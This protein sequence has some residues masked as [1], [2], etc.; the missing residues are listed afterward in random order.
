MAK[1]VTIPSAQAAT[2]MGVPGDYGVSEY[3]G[4]PCDAFWTSAV[5]WEEGEGEDSLHGKPSDAQVSVVY[6]DFPT[7]QEAL[8]EFD[9]IRK[10]RSS[11]MV[12]GIPVEVLPVSSSGDADAFLYQ[13]TAKFFSGSYTGSQ[14]PSEL[15]GRCGRRLLDVSASL[16]T[17][18]SAVADGHSPTEENIVQRS[19]LP[20][21]VDTQLRAAYSQI[22]AG[23]CGQDN[24]PSIVIG[25]WHRVAG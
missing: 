25:P 15:I 1:C 19:R 4:F 24:P 12:N 18:Y 11:G 20:Q 6:I 9:A 10:L 17:F 7:Q 23:I 2:I 16:D 13:P 5:K 3:P 8:A 22:G 14:A 21:K